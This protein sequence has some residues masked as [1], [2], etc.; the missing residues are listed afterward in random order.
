M[1]DLEMRQ[2]VNAV[3]RKLGFSE[4]EGGA[5]ILEAQEETKLACHLWVVVVFLACSD[6][7][8]YKDPISA[9]ES[10]LC[11]LPGVK[12]TKPAFPRDLKSYA[13]LFRSPDPVSPQAAGDSA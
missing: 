6:W 11:P 2:R 9:R 7:Q 12:A 8:H 4:G 10:A 1:L 13:P 5:L 3:L